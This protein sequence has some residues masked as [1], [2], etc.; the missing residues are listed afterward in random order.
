MDEA[1]AAAVDSEAYAK[2]SDS[3]LMN[4]ERNFQAE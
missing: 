2:M 4:Y 3:E 1:A